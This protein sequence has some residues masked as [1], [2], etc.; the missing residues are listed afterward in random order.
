MGNSV[1]GEYYWIPGV[2]CQSSD[3]NH[4][5]GPHNSGY[6]GKETSGKRMLVRENPSGK[7]LLPKMHHLLPADVVCRKS[8]W[9][10]HMHCS[11][12]R[13]K[14]VFLCWTF[15]LAYSVQDFKLLLRI[16]EGIILDSQE[17]QKFPNIILHLK[18]LK[19]YIGRKIDK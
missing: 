2:N 6:Y 5:L 10:P 3:C 1:V 15:S 11:L 12:W 14:Q 17:M 4:L 13:Q 16:R 9:N 19:I 18:K 7:V 8:Q